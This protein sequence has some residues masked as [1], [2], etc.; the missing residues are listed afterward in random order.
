MIESKFWEFRKTRVF[1]QSHISGKQVFNKKYHA[2][3]PSGYVNVILAGPFAQKSTIRQSTHVVLENI[4]KD[5]M[6]YEW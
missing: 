3:G 2:D 6:N 1:Q 5:F 4:L